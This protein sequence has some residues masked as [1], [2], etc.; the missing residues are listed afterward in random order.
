MLR[1]MSLD[2]PVDRIETPL[3]AVP[4]FLDQRPLDGPVAL[5]DWRLNGLLTAQLQGGHTAGRLG[6][7]Y[8]VK[9]SRK[10]SAE[11]VMFVGC[12]PRPSMRDSDGQRVVDQLLESAVRAGFK[13]IT[14]GLPVDSAEQLPVWKE[15]LQAS[16]SRF[17]DQRL[18][19]QF[20]ACDPSAY[21]N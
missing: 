1:I 19:C 11:W 12:G 14:V 4:F 15:Y 8:L 7:R 21:T 13:Q 9:G 5:L 18:D 6:E 16:L 3:V 17:P 2:L 20:S 10:V